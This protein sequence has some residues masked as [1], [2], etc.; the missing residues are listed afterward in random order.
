MHGGQERREERGEP[1]T[2]K[3]GQARGADGGRTGGAPD[4]M[5]AQRGDGWATTS[6]ASEAAAFVANHLL[7]SLR[8]PIATIPTAASSPASQSLYTATFGC[9]PD[10][11]TEASLLLLPSPLRPSVRACL[12]ALHA[13]ASL[14]SI[15]GCILLAPH[16]RSPCT[17]PSLPISP[18]CSSCSATSPCTRR[19]LHSSWIVLN[20]APFLAASATR[21]S[22]FW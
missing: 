2:G 18:D 17:C 13:V 7:G 9:F 3:A 11:A 1:E 8:Q 6:P 4:H 21:K 19:G 20:H 5:P 10:Y 12:L 22:V 15:A 14:L 16:I